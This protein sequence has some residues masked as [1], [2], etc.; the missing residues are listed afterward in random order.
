MEGEKEENDNDKWWCECGI[1]DGGFVRINIT[2]EY[3]GGRV[4]N[5][6]AARFAF[7][8]FFLF[9]WGSEICAGR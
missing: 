1:L 2:R 5:V 7:F 4:I 8:L 3:R 9:L 6:D